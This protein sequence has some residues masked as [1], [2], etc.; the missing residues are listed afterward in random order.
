[1]I[2]V[3]LLVA[4]GALP[5]LASAQS[6][7][8]SAPPEASTPSNAPK[9]MPS[10]VPT[11]TPAEAAVAVKQTKRT[12]DQIV[13]EFF[14][15]LKADKVDAAY[16]T[17]DSEFAMVDRGDQSKTM[18]AQ[19]QK[20]LDAYGPVVSAEMVKEEKLGTH[21]LRRTYILAGDE[22]PL[23]W[24][25]YFYKPADRWKLIDLRID[26]AIAEWFDENRH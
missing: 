11:P 16:D 9:K 12:P 19:T 17:L 6:K 3:L 25:F 8:Q 2:R 15:A 1:M 26:D 22:L 5:A 7:I 13:D 23:R 20:A 14:A 10:S 4:L 21:L 24:K 18:R